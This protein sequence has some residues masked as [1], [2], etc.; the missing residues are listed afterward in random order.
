[1]NFEFS[2]EQTAIAEMADG[3]FKGCCNDARLGEF[4]A[5]DAP[6]MQDVWEACVH[7]GLHTL[8]LPETCGGGGLGMTELMLVLEAQG[9][10]LAQVPLWRHQ[11]AAV[12]LAK[13]S[14]DGGGEVVHN[15]V[16]G[17]TPL[18][19]DIGAGS[20]GYLLAAHRDGAD[21]RLQGRV[22]ALALGAV[23]R[24][25]VLLVEAGDT[26]RL[27]LV[28]LHAAGI[29]TIPG[30]LC[31]GEAV[32]DVRFA[33]VYLA[34]SALLPVAALEWLQ[35]RVIAA[36]AA[37]QLGVCSEQVRRAVE[38]VNERRQFE[39]V[40][41]SFQAVQMTLADTSI[42]IEALRS[43]LWQLVYRLDAGLSAT[44]QALAVGYLACEAGHLV[45][46]KAQHV[47]GGVGVDLSYPIHRY[48]YW[49]RALGATLGGAACNLEHLGHWLA[50]HNTLG[51]KYDLEEHPQVC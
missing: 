51:W 35:N 3:L 46:H 33:D 43:S 41:A 39:R 42:A 45:G 40:I 10:T 7:V 5:G 36:L 22:E 2:E 1:M 47:H 14:G 34:D 48:L 23:V 29:E 44:P 15:A 25:A 11:L 18:T 21:W 24:H 12:T 17:A 16:Q 32:A 30:R 31:H 13:F 8:A 50:G 26:A 19:L 9:R 4:D 49:S 28:D 6:L 27:A 37:L 38:Y 20:R